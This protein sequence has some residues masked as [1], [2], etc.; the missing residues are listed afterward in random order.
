MVKK[1]PKEIAA[2]RK[3]K[4]AKDEDTSKKLAIA[5]Q[6]HPRGD[7]ANADD[8]NKYKKLVQGGMS[9]RKAWKEYQYYLNHD[10]HPEFKTRLLEDGPYEGPYE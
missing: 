1:T 7:F 10:L 6:L 4:K 5:I 8:Y 2:I 3:R 9:A